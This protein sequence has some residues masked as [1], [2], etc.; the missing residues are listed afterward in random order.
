MYQ[1]EKYL[2]LEIQKTIIFHDFQILL[3]VTERLM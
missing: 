1:D 3:N 2:I